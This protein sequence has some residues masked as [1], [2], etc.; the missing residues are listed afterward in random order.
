[1][2]CVY[3][4]IGKHTNIFRTEHINFAPIYNFKVKFIT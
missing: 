4:A 2:T 3:E 1:M